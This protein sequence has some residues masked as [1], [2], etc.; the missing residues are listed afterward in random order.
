MNF[1][2]KRLSG[3]IVQKE[4]CGLTDMATENNQIEKTFLDPLNKCKIFF[5]VAKEGS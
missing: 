2:G 5:L 4:W 3:S 1:H